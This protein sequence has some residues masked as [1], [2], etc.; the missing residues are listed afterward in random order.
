MLKRI[1]LLFTFYKSYLIPSLLITF[2]CI[3]F[4]SLFGGSAL[5]VL[6]WFKILTLGATVYF[7]GSYKENEFYY[8][9]N[10]GISKSVLWISTITFDFALFIVLIILTA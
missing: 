4:F 2:V 10:L 6:L 8:Y 3:Y 5:G 9:Q 1:G 7:I